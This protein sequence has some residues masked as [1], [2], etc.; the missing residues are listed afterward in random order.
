MIRNSTSRPLPTVVVADPDPQYQRYIISLLQEEFRCI[1]TNSLQETYQVLQR[2]RPT[3]LI[4][5]PNQPDGD[6]ITLIQR[7][8]ADPN[9][10]GVLTACVTQRASIMDKVRAFRAGTDDYVVKPLVPATFPGQMLL[11]CRAGHMARSFAGRG[12]QPIGYLNGR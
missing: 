3:L 7:L 1:P 2:E 5:E 4:L 6:G 10:Q 9:L 11:L 8:Q 12:A